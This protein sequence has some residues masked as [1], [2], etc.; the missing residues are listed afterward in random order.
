MFGKATA[1]LFALDLGFKVSDAASVGGAY[2]YVTDDRGDADVTLSTFG[3]SAEAAVGP[4]TLNGFFLYQ[5]GDLGNDIDAGAA[6]TLKV[7]GL[8]STSFAVQLN[9]TVPVTGFG[10]PCKATLLIVGA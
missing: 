2:Y 9:V 7:S 1:D 10:A 3:L 8:P 5:V 4:A 6:T